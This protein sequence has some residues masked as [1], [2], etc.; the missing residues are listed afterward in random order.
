MGH[1]HVFFFFVGVAFATKGFQE[2]VAAQTP[3]LLESSVSLRL[4]LEI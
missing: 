1:K 2:D 3:R 4:L